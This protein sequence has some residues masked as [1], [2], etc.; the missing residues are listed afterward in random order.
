MTV[1]VLL[2]DDHPIIRQGMRNLLGGISDFQIIG[3]AG[4]GFEALHKIE[5]SKPNVLVDVTGYVQLKMPSGEIRLVPEGCLATL[6]QVA[7]TEHNTT[8]SHASAGI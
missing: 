7:N 8:K 4:D 1:T 6:G 5:L 3:E 2:V